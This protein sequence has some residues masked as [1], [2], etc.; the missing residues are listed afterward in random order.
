MRAAVM[1]D[2]RLV[3]DELPDPVPGGGQ[4]VARTLTCGICGSDLHAL[5]HADQVAEMSREAS[6]AGGGAVVAFDASADLVMGH[7]YCVEV[8]EPGPGVA[9]IEPGD[10]IVSMP[11]VYDDR[12][13]HAVGYSNCY[14]GGYAEQLVVSAGLALPVPE[15]VTPDVAALT[16]PMAVGL[17]AVNRSGIRPGEAAVVLG[18]GPVG[19]AVVAALKTLGVE[20]VVAADLSATRRALA[21][22]LGADEVVDPAE[23]P[24]VEAWRRVD[25][26]R[27]LVIFEAVGVPGMIDAAMR[28]AP[29]LARVCVVG[30]CMEADRIH[31]M[32]GIVKEL[33]VTFA[34][35]Y[36]PVEFAATLEWI[37]GGG[38]DLTPLLTGRVGLDGLPGAFETLADPGAHAKILVEPGKRST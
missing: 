17:H 1:R 32:R 6:V 10:V 24:A 3:I 4:L 29:G 9:G 38:V 28:E 27:S 30:V 25:G 20:P 23:E 15:G 7:E 18:C 34:L 19:L 22:H 35:G 14:P 26:R 33:S 13:F 16:E 5:P 21:G 2:G 36:D 12:G 11:V 8:V 31:P 37:A